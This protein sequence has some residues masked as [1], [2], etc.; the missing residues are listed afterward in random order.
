M[1]APGIVIVTATQ[2][3][4][5]NTPLIKKTFSI[6]VLPPEATTNSPVIKVGALG[7]VITVSVKGAVAKV[8][9]DGVAA[10]IGANKVKAG[11]RKVSI[12]IAGKLVYSKTFNVK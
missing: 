12:S 1:R 11:A 5:A 10:K 9:I 6:E 3:A 2:P 4:T 7:K 8:S